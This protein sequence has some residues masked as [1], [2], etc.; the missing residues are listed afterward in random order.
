[1]NFLKAEWR[2]LA[3][4]N[5]EINPDLLLQYLPEGTELDF[6]RGKCYVSLV[7]FMFLNTRLLGLPIPFHRNFEE[8]NLRFYVKKKENGIWKRGVVFIKEI[9]PKPA[10]SFV[11]NSIYK[12]NYHT[13]PMKNLIHEKEDELLIRYSWKD[14]SWHS[15]QITAGNKAQTMETDSEFEFITE[16]YWGFTK[17]ENKTSEYEVCH[18]KWEYYLIKDYKLDIHFGNIYG[19]DFESLD[20]QEP[21]SVMLAEGSEIQVR[22]KKYTI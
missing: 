11:A 6:Y 4:I 14:K 21:V 9:V 1:M 20:R 16:H 2:K 10:L 8:V 7:G 15:L 3:I 22:T 13:M 18:P 12:E 17:N 5:Y 19:K